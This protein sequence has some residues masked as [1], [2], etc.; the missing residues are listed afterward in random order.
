MDAQAADATTRPNQSL[1]MKAF[2]TGVA[3]RVPGT[4][5]PIAREP[6]APKLG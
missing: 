2:D 6:G 4:R 1:R 3:G 5:F